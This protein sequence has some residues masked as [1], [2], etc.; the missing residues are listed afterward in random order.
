MPA[1]FIGH[2]S[3]MNAVENN[4]VTAAWKKQI[5]SF[6]KPKAILVISAHW[7]VKA[8][9][10]T[11]SEHPKTIHDFYGFPPELFAIQ[12]PA[13]GSQELV[14]SIKE[15]LSPEITV[16]SDNEQWGIDHGAWSVL[17]HL[18]PEAD[19]PVVQLSIDSSKPIEY[20]YELGK[21][22]NY[23]REQGVLI[24][25]SGNVVHNLRM[26]I[27]NENALPHPWAIEFNSYIKDAIV[28]DKLGN[29]LNYKTHSAAKYAVP[30]EDHFLPLIYILGCKNESDKIEVFAEE[31]SLG[32]LSMTSYKF[33]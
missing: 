8:T 28:N 10:V 4:S 21:K 24:L 19:I 25:G 12:Y 6:P 22:L 3:P 16:L 32:A 2:G 27:W 33:S 1:L 9:A 20:H 11:S 17:V 18:Y 26:I 15:H 23:L 13:P 5:E 30:T 14:K 31:F 7:Y 29:V